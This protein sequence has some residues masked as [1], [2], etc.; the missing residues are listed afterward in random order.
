M[1][2]KF[3]TQIQRNMKAQVLKIRSDNETESK[4]ATL[5]SYYEKLGILHHTSIAQMPQYNGVVERRNRT[6]VKA[7]ITMLIFS[8][9]QEL[10]WV[11][12][13][14]TACFTQN[15]YLIHTRFIKEMN[16]ILSQD[17]DNLF[18][19]LYEEYYATRTPEV[20]NNSAA[21]TLNNEDTSSSSS[22]IFE[23]NDDPQIAPHQKNQLHKN[24]Q[25]QFWILIMMNKF[26]KT[27]QILMG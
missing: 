19:P 1:I 25:L 15:R 11:K 12:A 22:I 4:N 8:K 20:S 23:D 6:L 10:L 13:I 24:P 21:N 17:L 9:L 3:L 27:L 18:G 14:S 16:E 2:M 5:K 26:K 7:A